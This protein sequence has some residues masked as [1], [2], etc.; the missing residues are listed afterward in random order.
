MP[1]PMNLSTWPPRGRSAAVRIS[2]TSLSRSTTTGPGAASLIG[3]KPRMSANQIT[4][5]SLSTEPRMIGAG[6]DAPSGVLAEIGPQQSGGDDV[7]GVRLHRQRQRRQ[8]R[9]HER[10]IVVGE[11]AFPV[12]RERIDDSRSLRA[13]ALSPRRRR[14]DRRCSRS[15]PAAKN[16]SSTGKSRWSG[17][18]SRRRR[19]EGLSSPSRARR[20]RC[21]ERARQPSPL[22]RRCR[23]RIA[24]AR[25]R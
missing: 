13:V 10:R 16:S 2:K 12:G 19:I 4:A 17:P 14:R 1:S 5:R 20:I 3:V 11:A 18:A 23:G 22:L 7:A 6:M 8:R 24:R 25:W 21:V 15:R 9:L